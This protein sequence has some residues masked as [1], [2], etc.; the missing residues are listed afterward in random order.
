LG[1]NKFSGSIPAVVGGEPNHEGHSLANM[2]QLFN[3]HSTSD[4]FRFRDRDGKIWLNLIKSFFKKY[5]QNT[6]HLLWV[7]PKRSLSSPINLKE[8][9]EEY[10]KAEENHLL[11]MI[12]Q[13]V[14]KM[15]PV[16]LTQKFN[17]ASKRPT[18]V[19]ST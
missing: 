19:E 7:D 6:N 18:M 13:N 4:L 15:D 14:R 11:T 5:Y 9:I 2:G 1:Q 3:L 17:S 10:I 8:I 16:R 12:F